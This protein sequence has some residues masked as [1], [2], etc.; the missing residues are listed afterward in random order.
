VSIYK[1]GVNVYPSDVFKK[2]VGLRVAC[3][4]IPACYHALKVMCERRDVRVGSEDAL[5]YLWAPTFQ[6]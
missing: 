3:Y 5:G 4:M 1:D 2:G 6:I